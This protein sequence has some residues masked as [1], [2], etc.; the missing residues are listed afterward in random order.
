MKR[1]ATLLLLL[2]L[3]ATTAAAVVAARENTPAQAEVLKAE[4]DPRAWREFASAEGRFAVL[5]PGELTLKTERMPTPDGAGIPLYVHTLRTSAEYGVIY[6]DYPFA[7][8]GAEMKGR[9]L[10]EGARGAVASVGAR[11]LDMKEITLGEHPGRELKELMRDGRVMHARMYVVGSRLYQVAVTLPKLGEADAATAFAEEVAARFLGSFR[12]LEEGARE[13]E[14]DRLIK[15][16]REKGEPVY[17]VS[18][19]AAQAPDANAGWVVSKPP[20]AYPELA[21]AARAQGTVAVQI[22]VDEEGRVIAAQAKSGHPLLQAAAV[23]AAREARFKP[24]TIE[25]K[26]VKLSGVVTYNFVLR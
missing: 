24:T 12:L 18:Q 15:A 25:G 10:D 2:A 20:P 7:V 14:V 5:V 21:R 1:L 6:A 4:R 3:N 16:L 23:K 9:L 8:T 17:G 13:G 11:L 22:V 26:R 19:S